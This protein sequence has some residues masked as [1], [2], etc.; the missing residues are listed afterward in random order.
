MTT[1]SLSYFVTRKSKHRHLGTAR[2]EGLGL[3]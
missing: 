3:R 1:W 2:R